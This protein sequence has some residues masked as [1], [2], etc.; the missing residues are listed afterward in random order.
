MGQCFSN[1]LE[2]SVEACYHVSPPHLV[3][4]DY[5]R[6]TKHLTN[7]MDCPDKVGDRECEDSLVSICI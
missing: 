4:A 7:L 5:T 2:G 3:E 6:L 1:V